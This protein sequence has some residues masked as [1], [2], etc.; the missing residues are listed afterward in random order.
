MLVP[1]AEMRVG[2]VTSDGDGQSVEENTIGS[3]WCNSTINVSAAA[4]PSVGTLLALDLVELVDWC[5]SFWER[6]IVIKNL[7]RC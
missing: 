3:S 7:W 6:H 1:A 2:G 4:E 5:E